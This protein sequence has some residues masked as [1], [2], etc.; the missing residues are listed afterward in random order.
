MWIIY[1]E[2]K[3]VIHHLAT[4]EH[5]NHFR[6]DQSTQSLRVDKIALVVM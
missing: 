1:R 2:V 3:T 4:L 5:I 6:I